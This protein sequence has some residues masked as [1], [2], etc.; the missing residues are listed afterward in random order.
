M[1]EGAAEPRYSA[2]ASRSAL[3][4]VAA[5]V[6]AIVVALVLTPFVL[7]K[8]EASLYGLAVAVGSVYEYLSL[9]RGGIGGAL[10]RFVTL[11]HHGD[12]PDLA[13]AYYAAGFWWAAM[14]RVVLLTAG[15]ALAW[16]LTGFFHLEPA[17]R[18]GAAVGVALVFLAS[19]INDQG[20]LLQ[21]PTYATGRTAPISL[22]IALTGWLR[23]AL[24]VAGLTWIGATLAVYG[25]TLV[26]LELLATG[27]FLLLAARARTVGPAL[28][29]PQ[30][31]APDVRRELFRYGG[32]ALLSQSATLLYLSTDNV[33]IGR[34]YGPEAVTA[35][36]LGTRWAPLVQGFLVAIVS[37]LT[38]IFTSLEARGETA[39]SR[40]ALLRVVR[41]TAAL[42]VPACLVPCVVGESFLVRWV[43]EEY[44]TSAR[45]M[46]AMLAP[47]VF[48]GALAPLWMSLIARGRIGWVASADILVAVG[49][50]VL[51]L[52]LALGFHLGLLGFALG[53]TAAILSKNL[54]LR[55]L[56]ARRDPA[57]PPLGLV[58]RPLFRALLGGA[59]GLALLWLT[60]PLYS[61]SLAAVMVA[62]LVGGAVCLAG[63]LLAGVGWSGTRSLF[64]L[65][66]RAGTGRG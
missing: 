35:Y 22:V 1:S 48:D 28:P 27:A 57:T 60:R 65:V 26:V 13:R 21:I 14:L 24:V 5:R 16:P 45:Y 55:P 54:L 39:R 19:V 64:V 3:A 33:L 56:M 51:S 34:I 47:M 63:S 53:N 44:R 20:V 32:L 38:P 66:R 18:S 37:G 23:V 11:H 29:R 49:N 40:E 42:A 46:V 6:S 43:G 58:L 15:V 4:A 12:R 30:L 31:G 17:L 7:G 8:L 59:P 2:V 25:G 41:V 9:L 52:V 10:R 36:S 62:G 50:V 61:G